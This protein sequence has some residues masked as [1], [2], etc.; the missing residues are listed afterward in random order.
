MNP[1]FLREDFQVKVNSTTVAA[2]DRI[3]IKC[4]FFGKVHLYC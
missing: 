4:K 3:F 2:Y 1:N